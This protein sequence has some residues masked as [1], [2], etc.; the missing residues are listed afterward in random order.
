MFGLPI[1]GWHQQAHV[2]IANIAVASQGRGKMELAYGQ[3]EAK[4]AAMIRF[5]DS[6]LRR[7][8]DWHVHPTCPAGHIG[9]PSATDMQTWLGELDRIDPTRYVGIIATAVKHGWRS[10]PY[11]HGWVVRGTNATDRF[12][13]P[14]RS[15][16]G[17][18]TYDV[19]QLPPRRK[20]SRDSRGRPGRNGLCVFRSGAA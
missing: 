10:P 18:R 3:L 9:E 17:T 15:P 1:R 16:Q 5:Q 14:Q 11:L 19:D 13:S 8:G 20:G 2:A 4:E 7:L 6:P 12:A